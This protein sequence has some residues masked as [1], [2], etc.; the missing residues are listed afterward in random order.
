M[1]KSDDLYEVFCAVL[2]LVKE[3][4]TWRAMVFYVDT[5]TDRVTSILLEHMNALV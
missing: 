4:C 1:R 3:G 2:Y 5:A